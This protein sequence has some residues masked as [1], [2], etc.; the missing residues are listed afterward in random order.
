M[1]IFKEVKQLNDKIELF[2]R[3]KE[4]IKWREQAR[5][6]KIK[7][8]ASEKINA[9]DTNINYIKRLKKHHAKKISSASCF[10]VDDIGYVLAELISK[11]EKQSYSYYIANYNGVCIYCEE[12]YGYDVATFNNKVYLINKTDEINYEYNEKYLSEVGPTILKN[13]PDIIVLS[14]VYLDDKKIRFYDGFIEKSKLVNVKKYDY[15]YDFIN[16]LISY[17]IENNLDELKKEEL[18]NLLDSFLNEY[19]IGY[20]KV[21][22]GV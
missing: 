19:I 21:R 22:K 13:N 12:G 17:K 5:I 9:C 2:E 6:K 20:S 3:E 7:D 8:N 10:N 18:F 15:I 14:N 16:Y 1:E 11:V 4:E